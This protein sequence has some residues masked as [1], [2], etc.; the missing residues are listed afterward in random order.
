MMPTKAP[1]AE[2]LPYWYYDGFAEVGYRFDLNG[3]DKNTLGKFYKYRD[4]RPGVFGNFY[5]GAHRTQPD[6]FRPL[7][8]ERRLR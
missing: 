7:G 3:A 6:R 4:L 8:Q 2:P 5:F 1:A